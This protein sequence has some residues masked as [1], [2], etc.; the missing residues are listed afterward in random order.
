M[1][2]ER[3]CHRILSFLAAGDQTLGL[4]NVLSTHSALETNIDPQAK[5]PPIPA[6]LALGSFGLAPAGL[7]PKLL[8]LEKQNRKLLLL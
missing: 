1:A 2:T 7:G 5:F 8:P 6:S 3:R 4:M